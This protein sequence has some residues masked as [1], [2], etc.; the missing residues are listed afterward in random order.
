MNWKTELFPQLFKDITSKA[1]KIDQ[2]EF[3]DTGHFAVVDQGQSFIA[4]YNN[5]ESLVWDSD[6]PVIILGIILEL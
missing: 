6:L 4:G 5:D 2:S 1:H 3:L